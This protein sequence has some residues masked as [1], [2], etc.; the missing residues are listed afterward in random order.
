MNW[1]IRL[2]IVFVCFAGMMFTLVYKSYH[3][4][5]ELVS[6][7]YYSDELKYQEK[8]DGRL[9]ASKKKAVLIEQNPNSIILNLP[10]DSTARSI[11]GEAWFYS[12]NDAARDRRIRLD[13]A[14][15]TRQVIDKRKLSAGSYELKLSWKEDGRVYYHEANLT[16]L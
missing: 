6:K 16:I 14:S 2:I 7:D 1:G 11:T 4:K 9:N 10:T 13:S 8:I 12:Q 5:F 15:G 3:T